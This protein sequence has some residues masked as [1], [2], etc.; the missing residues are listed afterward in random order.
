MNENGW[1][2]ISTDF[3][4]DEKIRLIKSMP[5]GRTM[6][7]IWLQILCLTEKKNEKGIPYLT[8]QIAYNAEMLA[9][10][11]GEELAVI[12]QS[13]EVFEGFG[14]IETTITPDT[15]MVLNRNVYIQP[16]KDT[17]WPEYEQ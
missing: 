10:V 17:Q 14:M 6:V 12:R 16:L 9:T 13:L 3:F 11:L 2:L 8:N 15:F 7:L 5:G 4:K 1:V